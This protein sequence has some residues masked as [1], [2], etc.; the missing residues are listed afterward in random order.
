MAGR[1]PVMAVMQGNEGDKKTLAIAC[2]LA[3]QRGTS[4]RTLY[5]VE[6]PPSLPLADWHGNEEKRARAT[7]GQAEVVVR[8][9]GC[10]LQGTVLPARSAGQTIIDETIEWAVQ[11]VV[12]AIPFKSRYGDA[13]MH[14][15]RKALCEVVIWR[16]AGEANRVA[17]DRQD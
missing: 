1:P 11:A 10:A 16:A 8:S 13:A 12:L 15:L 14:V 4:L 17:D 5:V 7:L 6:V 2:N 3:Q 9:S